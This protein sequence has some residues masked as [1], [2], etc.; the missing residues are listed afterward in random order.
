[1]EV[2]MAASAITARAITQSGPW[3]PV[4]G[5]VDL[6][7]PE[8]GLNVLVGPAGS[9]RTA[10][11]M[12]L[13]GRMKVK[14]GHLDVLGESAPRGIFRRS[15]M[16]GVEGLDSIYE[17]VRVVDLLTEQLRWDAPWY[18]LVGRA[19]PDDLR[20]VCGPV[21]GDLPLP[22]LDEYVEELPELDGLLLRIALGNTKNPPLLVVGAIDQVAN[23]R[24]QVLLVDRLVALGARQTVIT[25]S[26]NPLPAEAGWH[27]QTHVPN[28]MQ[29]ELIID[30][31][32]ATREGG[33]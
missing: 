6:D 5:P 31:I 18:T 19:R 33:R 1:M 16:V 23:A 29:H 7:I 20:R 9:G 26:A 25:A 28:L 13:A 4:Y 2:L 22:G 15:G 32:D 27:T 21:F 17:S 12:T 3:G 8:G 30:H 11:L 14:S 24:D 10:L